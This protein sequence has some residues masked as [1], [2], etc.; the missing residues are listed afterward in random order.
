[1]RELLDIF[2]RG[3]KH[4]LLFTQNVC[5]LSI[6]HLPRES[7][8]ETRPELMFEVTKSLSKVGII[9]ELSV[10]VDLSRH[11]R[12][13]SGD[14]LHLIKQCIF[15]RASSE[16][17]KYA[18]SVKEI[19]DNLLKSAYTVDITGNVTEFGRSFF[20]DKSEIKSV[21]EVWFVASS[22]GRGQAFKFS[23]NDKSLLPAAAVA[24]QLIPQERE[25]FLP[26][27]VGGI[28]EGGKPHHNGTVFCYLP[29][30]IHSGLPVHIN[31]AFA[32]DSSR[33]HLKEKT[34]DDKTC[35]GV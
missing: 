10:P 20:E 7:V 12:N 22:M 6:F 18:R 35:V 4:L 14:V 3:A 28:A 8:E 24:V 34:E 1:M 16:V 27:P 5:Q 11:L 26:E 33:R 19:D 13:V 17:A 30:P 21:S 29:L 15:L 9:R 32:V 31:G 23:V 25:T 2:V